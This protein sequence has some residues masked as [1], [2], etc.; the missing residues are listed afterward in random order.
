MRGLRNRACICRGGSRTAQ[1]R[2]RG[3]RRLGSISVRIRGGL[4]PPFGEVN[5]PLRIQIETVLPAD[6]LV[7]NGTT[8]VQ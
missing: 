8:P 6:G 4:T 1:R 7:K 3:K 2:G 5:S